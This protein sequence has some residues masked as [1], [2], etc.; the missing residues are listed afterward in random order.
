LKD[1]SLKKKGGDFMVCKF[2]NGESYDVFDGILIN[3]VIACRYAGKEE[4]EF[5]KALDE[6]NLEKAMQIA[7]NHVET[8]GVCQRVILDLIDAEERGLYISK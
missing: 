6:H 4:E 1:L 2:K 3:R 7:K 8:C 5:W